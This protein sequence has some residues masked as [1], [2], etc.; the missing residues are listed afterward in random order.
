MKSPISY[1]L[2][3]LGL[4]ILALLAGLWAGLLRMGWSL[5]V[6]HPT[7]LAAHGPLMIC[8]FFGTLI[9]LERAVALRQSWPY[10]GVVFSGIGG[11]LVLLGVADA[12]GPVLMTLGSLWLV[13]IFIAILRQHLTGYTLV[14]CIGAICWLSGSLLWLSGWP[15]SRFVLWWAGFL[16]LTIAGERLELSRLIPRSPNVLGLF[17][18]GCAVFLFGLVVLLFAF[19]LGVRLAGLGMLAMAIW[20]FTFDIARRTVRKP[21]LTRYI[22]ICLL[23]GY[24][25]LAAGGLAAMV[26]GGVQAGPAYDLLLHSV[27]IGFVFSMIFGHAPIIFPAILDVPIGYKPMLYIPLVLLQAS[28]ILRALGD[29]G[30]N[31]TLRQWGGMLNAIVI[32]VFLGMLA[33]QVLQARKTK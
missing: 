8:G 18:T 23:A 5:P 14:M 17:Y 20:L 9:I 1:R 31:Y 16:V 12:F 19:D 30:G 29:L 6:L 2:P 11:L 28:L 24:F 27:Y 15:V 26:Y 13:L 7:L 4:A 32:L 33:S 10:L 21:G 3:L 25:W 22:A